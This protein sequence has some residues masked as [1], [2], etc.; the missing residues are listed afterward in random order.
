[1]QLPGRTLSV[2]LVW[3][4]IRGIGIDAEAAEQFSRA[5][6]GSADFTKPTTRIPHDLAIHVL[7]SYV[8]RTGDVSIGLRAGALAEP[9]D[10]EPLERLSQCA[11]TL[12]EALRSFGRCVR[13]LHGAAVLWLIEG[14]R[15]ALWRFQTT[16]G[17]EPSP[18]ANDFIIACI[19][20]FANRCATVKEPAVEVHFTHARPAYAA[21]Y[22]RV[23]Q[24][25]RI[26]FGM[27]HN[28]LVFRR[29][30]LEQAMPWSH[31]E[32]RAGME[33][34]L[35][36]KRRGAGA[37]LRDRVS[38]LVL[39]SLAGGGPS[40]PVAAGALGMS[41]ATLRRRLTAEG[42]GFNEIVNDMRRTVAEI[43]LLSSTPAGEI[44]QLL[45]FAHVPAFYAAFRRWTGATPAT[46]RAQLLDLESERQVAVA[47]DS[48]PPPAGGALRMP[49]E[50]A[51]LQRQSVSVG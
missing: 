34:A 42:T 2:R 4:F 1:M 6:F 15:E 21:A 12:R 7:E 49:M 25:S 19:G 47:G 20:A 36:P 30:W 16:D 11:D 37:D 38:E 13:T 51:A 23:F 18:A 28:G 22:E 26:R 39:G 35:L 41:V 46:Y 32:L 44:A 50:G 3:P 5:G 29:S 8:Q 10:L 48:Q 40:M 31:P 24:T 33:L 9:G 43:F 45:G 17:T 14:P 27:P